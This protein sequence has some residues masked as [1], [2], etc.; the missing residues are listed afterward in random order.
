MLRQAEAFHIQTAPAVESCME[1]GAG[2]L[3]LQKFSVT[4]Q[5]FS[6]GRACGLGRVSRIAPRHPS[7]H[8]R[9]G[10][11]SWVIGNIVIRNWWGA[12]RREGIQSTASHVRCGYEITENH[13]FTANPAI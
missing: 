5:Q 7:P 1:L 4:F 13:A 2:R 10:N 11:L 8:H 6:Y 12:D 3:K 9:A